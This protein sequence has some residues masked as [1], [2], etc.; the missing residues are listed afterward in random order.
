M[1]AQSKRVP[2]DPSGSQVRTGGKPA[3]TRLA[4]H[5]ADHYSTAR[6]AETWGPKTAC[7]R[8]IDV[9]GAPRP[10]Q[11]EKPVVGGYVTNEVAVSVQISVWT[12][13]WAQAQRLNGAAIQTDQ[14]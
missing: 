5:W 14:R 7:Q 1:H 2:D 11:D 12:T 3:A 4:P 10:L 6:Q 9:A 13:E 8:I